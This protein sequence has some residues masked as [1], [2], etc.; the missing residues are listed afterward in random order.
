MEM[1]HKEVL[2]GYRLFFYQVFFLVRLLFLEKKNC[3]KRFHERQPGN[4]IPEVRIVRTVGRTGPAVKPEAVSTA[5]FLFDIFGLFNVL[6]HDPCQ[7]KHGDLRFPT[8]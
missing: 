4:G 7:F 6:A 3:A 1:D 8:E 2:Y 5:S